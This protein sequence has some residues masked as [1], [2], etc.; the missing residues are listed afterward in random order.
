LLRVVAGLKVRQRFIG[1]DSH[2]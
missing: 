2:C 1:H